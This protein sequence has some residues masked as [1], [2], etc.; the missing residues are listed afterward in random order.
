MMETNSNILDKIMG[1]QTQNSLNEFQPTTLVNNLLALLKER[2][3]EIVAKRFGLAGSEMET[4]EGIGK[5]HSLN[6]EKIKENQKG[7]PKFSKEQNI[8]EL[9]TAVQL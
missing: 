9:D 2:D 1:S 4:L 5:K 6:R 3:R 8:P 7:S